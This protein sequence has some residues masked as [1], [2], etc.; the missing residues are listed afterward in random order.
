MPSNNYKL[1]TVL[2]ALYQAEFFID[3]KIKNIQQQTIFNDC[4]F[5]FINCQNLGNERSIYSQFMNDHD[6][7]TSIEIEEY[8]TLYE[9]W[10]RGIQSSKSDFLCNANVDDMWHPTYLEKCSDFLIQ[11]SDFA[12]VNSFVLGTE[13]PNQHD[14]LTWHSHYRHIAGTYP[15]TSAGP[16]PLWRRSLHDEYGLFEDYLVIG[17]ACMWESWLA[18]GERFGC[19]EEDLVLYFINYGSLERR[20][21]PLTST[22]FRDIDLVKRRAKFK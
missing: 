14:H 5:I 3:A 13:A 22:S 1:I 11:N 18:G 7:V 16:C 6:N 20:V 4:Q 12:C 8:T 17:D 19:I 21:D 2:L 15:N 9:S 10:N